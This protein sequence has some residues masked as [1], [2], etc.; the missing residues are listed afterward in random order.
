MEDIKV[1]TD[2]EKARN[3]ISV[4]F[5]SADNYYHPIKEALANAID[6]IN[7]HFD[8]GEV[9]IKLWDDN[10]TITI[11]DTGR[12]IPISGETNGIKN[13]KLLFETLFAGTKYDIT[14]QN[15]TGINGI[16]ETVTN[17]T[18]VLYEVHSYYDGKDHHIK[19][20]NGGMIQFYKENK[21]DHLSGTNI[22]FKLDHDVYTNITFNVNE[23]KEIIK[24]F[25]VSS[26]KVTFKL[27]YKMHHEKIHYDSPLQYFRE[28]VKNTATTN[29]F[30]LPIDTFETK[31]KDNKIEINKYNLML[32]TSTFPVQ[33]TYLNG[34]FLS[35]NG[36][37]YD[38]IISA[39]RKFGNNFCIKHKLTNNKEF[40][41][42]RSDVEDSCSFIMNV[43]SNN[44]EFTNQTKLSTS[45]K[46]YR[47][48]SEQ[49]TLKLLEIYEN[50]NIEDLIKF[51][52]H[53]LIV[54]NDNEN[55]EKARKKLK[56]RLSANI[57]TINN[58]VEKLVDCRNHGENS[59]LFIT[60]GNSA[61]GSVVQA[62]DASYQAAY[63]LRGK[64]LN[65]I[66]ANNK[67][68]FNNDVVLDL[69]KIIGAGI[70]IN[71]KPVKGL[72]E[73]NKNKLRFGKIMI[74]CDADADGYQIA[75]L[76][77]SLFYKL[78]RPIL[79]DGRLYFVKTP[80]YILKF[81]DDTSIYYHTEKEMR[82]NIGKVKKAYTL[83]RLK[84]LG[85]VPSNVMA[86]TAMNVKT[87]NILKI[88]S[89]DSFTTKETLMKW[90]GNDV[91]GRKSEINNNLP[92]YINID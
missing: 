85:E 51:Y 35:E 42:Q 39:I 69:I 80:L 30:T 44:V 3:K 48:Q 91:L 68:I 76:I 56:K 41:F 20:T 38:G 13:Y 57:E 45:K 7:N 77:I 14:K 24:H 1:L 6:E 73:F 75:C 5:G 2:R 59:E 82:E 84:G 67:T 26:P 72:P 90:M 19:Y 53:I 54:H 63:P 47:S 11:E 49:V 36:V 86:D 46:I 31:T 92:N 50:E 81:N 23:I 8:K 18:S 22:T 58:R 40:K 74:A 89:P 9:I 27:E 64:I 88:T 32:V 70:E 15:N 16:G 87:R 43:L 17:F 21:S 66:K 79:S 62:R 10:Q 37:I 28:N 34:T 60:E 71:N 61:L 29:I 52:K 83:S 78:M 4:W 33:E 55:N 12:G 65:C 25:A